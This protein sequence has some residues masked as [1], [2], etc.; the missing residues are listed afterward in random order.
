[1]VWI[2]NQLVGAPLGSTVKLECHTESSP[3]AISYWAFN[4]NMVL[5]TDRFKT[6]ER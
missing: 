6:A 1:M 2:P 4:D 5:D 3:R